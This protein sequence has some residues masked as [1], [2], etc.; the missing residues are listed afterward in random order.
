MMSTEDIAR[1]PET[2]NDLSERQ[3][4]WALVGLVA[5]STVGFW[6]LAC[7]KNGSFNSYGQDT[8]Q[9]SYA[10][11]QSLRGHWFRSFA[12]DY[13][14]LGSHPNFLLF[15]WLPVFW[16]LRSV[17]TLFFLQSLTLCL[18]AWP[19]YLLA[20]QVTGNRV[21]ALI[22]AA[23]L[24][25]FP[26]V[27]RVHVAELH[28]DPLGLAPLLFA[29]L[30]FEWRN[31]KWFALFLAISL[32]AK[33]TIVLNTVLF[34]V[35]ALLRR[36][37][38]RWVAFPLVWSAGYFLFVRQVVMPMFGD[39][40][41]GE[42]YSQ[43]KYFSGWG[44]TNSEALRNMATQPGRV[45]QTLAS[46]DRIGYLVNF[47][48]PFL[49]ALPFGSWAW[50]TALPAMGVNLMSDWPFLRAFTHWYGLLPGAQIWASFVLA[51][52]F[53]SRRLSAWFGARDYSRSLCVVVLVVCLTQHHQWLHP[54]EYQRG[55]A[56]QAR[57]E[58][59]A[60]IPKTASVICGDHMLPAF[61]DRPFINSITALRWHGQDN[62]RVFD[63]EYLV[64]DGNYP[65]LPGEMAV[66]Q[67]LFTFISQNA[68]YR[69]LFA[70]DNVFV[71]RRVG[72]P[73]GA[74]QW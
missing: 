42:L 57:L 1:S 25:V 4:N 43:A 8:A 13:S 63:Y 17:N 18:A 3:A 2:T 27:A 19:G 67:K 64:F 66:Q 11:F 38:W 29:F 49:L 58:A 5:L 40:W 23:A 65:G 50:I 56:H 36:R 35:Y 14:L 7:Y 34:S 46:G 72:Q 26:P 31:F 30:F 21:T 39:W 73:G 70:K 62:N 52:P 15:L 24:I 60:S 33:E 68:A 10:F 22:A 54:S 28:D 32:L 51:L 6:L 12:A 53:W 74:I 16:L 9:Y 71:F 61:V 69:L 37:D 45:L 48:Q 55:Q 59:I 47:L 20:R 44:S 41:A